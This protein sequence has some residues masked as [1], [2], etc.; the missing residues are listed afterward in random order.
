MMIR[1]AA[2]SSI[3]LRPRV[4]SASR[5]SNYFAS[6]FSLCLCALVPLCFSACAHQ[7]TKTR[8]HKELDLY[9]EENRGQAPADARFVA[10]GEGYN[11]LLTPDG[12]ELALRHARRRFRLSTQL[13]GANPSPTIQGEEQQ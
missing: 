11:L 2:V 6:L 9:F 3:F 1:L 4:M 13:I 8:R 12:N 10:R 7:D 5:S